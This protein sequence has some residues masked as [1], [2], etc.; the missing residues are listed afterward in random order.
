MIAAKDL[1]TIARGRLRDATVLLLAKRFDGAVYLCGYS[2]ELAL[3]ARI[4]QTLKWPGFPETGREFEG[5]QSLRTHDLELLLRLSGVAGRIK[6]K[7]VAEWSA[8][9]GWTPEKRYQAIGQSTPQQATDM[10]RCVKRLLDT[11]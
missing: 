3:K 5:L 2:V 9:A 4:C 7:Y 6:V 10:V 1:R 8:V 11:I